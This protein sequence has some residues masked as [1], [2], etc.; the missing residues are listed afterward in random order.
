M[1]L[2]KLKKASPKAKQTKKGSAKAFIFSSATMEKAVAINL[3]IVVSAVSLA[4]L[5]VISPVL[6]ETYTAHIEALLP[7]LVDF[8]LRS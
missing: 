5:W 1:I 6:A 7:V 2:K 3:T 8:Y 4:L